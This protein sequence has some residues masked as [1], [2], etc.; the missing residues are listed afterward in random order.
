M[1]HYHISQKMLSR[2]S[3]ANHLKHIS[4]LEMII[5]RHCMAKEQDISDFSSLKA[6]WTNFVLIRVLESSQSLEDPTKLT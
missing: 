3:T 1:L 6:A 4:F 2:S 5:K